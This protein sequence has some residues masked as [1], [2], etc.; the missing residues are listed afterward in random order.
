MNTTA[1]VLLAVTLGVAVV[2]WWAV[3]SPDRRR[4][5]LVA[6]PLTLVAL[7]GAAL[8]LDPADPTV[9]AWFVGALVLSLAGDVF[10]MLEE[11]F[12]VLGLASFLLGH[13]AY[14]AGFWVSGEIGGLPATLGLGLVIGLLLTVGRAVVQGV[15]LS[16]PA[17]T[18]PVLA[19]VGVISVMVVSA[20]GTGNPW[21]IVG[22]LL[23][24]ASDALIAW[25]KFIEPQPWGR[26]AIIVT[27]HLGQIGLVLSLL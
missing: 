17:M 13:V 9:R 2:D 8:A 22:A 1:G 11:K 4:V 24:Y 19:Y 25:N 12:F 10:L 16:E 14:I 26:L 6:K 18:A 27:Y 5:E 15:R 7:I 23:F 3:C 20:I 21:A